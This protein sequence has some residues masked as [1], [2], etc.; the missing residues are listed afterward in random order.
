MRLPLFGIDANYS[1]LAFNSA[2]YF[3]LRH[4]PEPSSELSNDVQ[5]LEQGGG[6]H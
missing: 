6:L 2:L 3:P 4:P 5:G 1:D